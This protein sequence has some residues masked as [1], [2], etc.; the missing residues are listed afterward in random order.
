MAARQQLAADQKMNSVC[1]I[2][3]VP[4]DYYYTGTA[5]ASRVQDKDHKDMK[6]WFSWP[7]NSEGIRKNGSFSA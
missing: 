6:V 4:D 2:D 1:Y 3:T 7:R 5:E